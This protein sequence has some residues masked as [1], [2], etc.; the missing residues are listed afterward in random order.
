[1]GG[2]FRIK[3]VVKFYGWK[4]DG[5][6][7]QGINCIPESTCGSHPISSLPYSTG[8]VSSKRCALSYS[9]GVDVS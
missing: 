8:V 1:M 6:G 5:M 4:F 3:M 7:A 2:S 9:T